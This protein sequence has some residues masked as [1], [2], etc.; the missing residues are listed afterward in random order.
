[1]HLTPPHVALNFANEACKG[2]G[3]VNVRIGVKEQ[4]FSFE[5]LPGDDAA[6]V[7]DMIPSHAGV[8]IA[9]SDGSVRLY[10]WASS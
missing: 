8:L 7:L 5:P 1:L 2:F 10:T 3:V 6:E 4:A 9:L